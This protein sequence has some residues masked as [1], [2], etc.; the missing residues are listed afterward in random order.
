MG[1]ILSNVILRYLGRQHGLYGLDNNHE[2]EID[3]LLDTGRDIKMGPNMVTK[4]FG[5]F[6]SRI[7]NFLR[8]I[9]FYSVC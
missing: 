2:S 3:M 8:E 6:K 1:N 5:M 9:S 4:N 7:S